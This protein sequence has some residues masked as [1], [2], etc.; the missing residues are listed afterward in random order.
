[1]RRNLIR[2]KVEGMLRRWRKSSTQILSCRFVQEKWSR[3]PG[4]YV[5]ARSQSCLTRED[6]NSVQNVFAKLYEMPRKY[7]SN[8]VHAADSYRDA[9]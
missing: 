5:L 3:F 7:L 2:L 8:Y 1:M 9:R 4:I 6:D